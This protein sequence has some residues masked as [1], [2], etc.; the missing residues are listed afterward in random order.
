SPRDRRGSAAAGG[1]R[2]RDFGDA[3]GFGALMDDLLLDVLRWL[4]NHPASAEP[5]IE[6]RARELL[7]DTLGCA[8]AGTA[9]PEVAALF[10]LVDPGPV[11]F[12]GVEAE[13]SAAGFAMGFAVAACWHEACEGLAAAHGRPG[14]HAIPAVLGPAMARRL[15]LAAVLDAIVAGYEIG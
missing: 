4:W 8:I 6:A 15:P 10:R 13:M 3:G 9:E 11:R 14:L 7:L 1:R 2:R 5:E 12:P